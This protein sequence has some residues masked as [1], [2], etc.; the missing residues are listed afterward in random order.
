MQIQ[1]IAR[2][3]AAGCLLFGALTCNSNAQDEKE[4]RRVNPKAIIG[5]DQLKKASLAVEQP[6]VTAAAPAAAAKK[7][8]LNLSAFRTALGS[9]VRLTRF[10]PA[11]KNTEDISGSSTENLRVGEYIAVASDQ[12]QLE[13][14]SSAQGRTYSPFPTMLITRN[15][16][17][18]TRNLRI[19]DYSDGFS[20]KKEDSSFEANI[21]VAVS[22]MG[23]PASDAQLETP[24]SIK[25]SGQNLIG[26]PQA[27]VI[28]RLGFAGEKEVI[29]RS[30][31]HSDPVRLTLRHEIDPQAPKNL[32]L[33]VS[34]PELTI[35]ANPPSIAGYGIESTEITISAPGT[36]AEGFPI[37][38]DSDAGTFDPKTIQIGT[39]GFATSRLWSDG[40]GKYAIGV[41]DDRFV[42]SGKPVHF[43]NPVSFLIAVALGAA[44]GATF[45]YLWKRS[46]G[47][48]SVWT[49]S[50]AF[51][52]GIGITI[53]AFAGFEIPKMLHLPSG[54][55]GLIVPAAT[56][57][58]AAILINA[59]YSALVG[60]GAK[61]D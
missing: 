13:P 2:V 41:L 5:S 37:T 3:V 47:R 18:T 23:N 20:W 1:A 59:I 45:I 40:T 53:A 12:I 42:V 48:A 52:F 15:A 35:S 56:A 38:L 54:R 33:P 46:G 57:F 58:M 16:D 24:I 7:E 10:D 11:T 8:T 50:A 27:V 49:W 19:D 61:K 26:A 9:N 6:A 36:L 22:D 32:D 25:I 43:L 31:G 30:E 44:L 55:A 60:S 17:G 14:L 34:R 39:A 28:G 29:V 4:I 51:V 21:S